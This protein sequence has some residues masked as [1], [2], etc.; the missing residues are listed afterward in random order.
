[1]ANQKKGCGFLITALLILI[2]GGGIAAFLGMSAFSTSKEFTEDINKGMSFM[3]PYTLNYTADEDTEVTIWL[4]SD[5]TTDLA[6][7]SVEFIEKQSG[8][9]MIASKPG[10]TSSLGNQ[11]LVA[12]HQ[13]EKGKVY[14]VKASGLADGHTLRIASVPSTSVFAIVGKGLGAFAI[15]GGCG[16][17]ALVFGIIGMIKY[18]GG[19]DKPSTPPPGAPPAM[20]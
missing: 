1:M 20:G 12:K 7:I 3:T 18:F 15:F 10:G 17:L 16:F 8:A 11:H 19:K 14:Q 5:A 13:V 6:P 2:G 9:S 4:T